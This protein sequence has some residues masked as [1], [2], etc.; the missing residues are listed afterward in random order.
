[1]TN[2]PI[3]LMGMCLLFR[4]PNKLFIQNDQCCRILYA[5]QC[6]HY[7]DGSNI[8]VSGIQIATVLKKCTIQLEKAFFS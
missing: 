3:L 2:N 5:P 8:R 6:V 4:C 1:M 7:L